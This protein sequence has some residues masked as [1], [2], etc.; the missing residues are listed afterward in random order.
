MSTSS[1]SIRQPPESLAVWLAESN[2]RVV[3]IA[4]VADWAGEAHIVAGY[5]EKIA[6]EL[7]DII[8]KTIDIDEWQDLS[9]KMGV[10]QVPTIILM[11]NHTV[12]DHIDGLVS[13]S[14]LKL[15][16]QSLHES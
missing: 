2:E 7:P 16:I 15:R 13:R 1:K 11:K 12:V 3:V 9:V 5:L 14:K 4:F 8:V 6:K 10:N